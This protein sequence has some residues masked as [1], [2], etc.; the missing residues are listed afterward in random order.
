VAGGIGPDLRAGRVVVLDRYYLSTAAY[1]GALGLDP[2]AIMAENE[3]FAPRPDLAFLLDLPVDT[4]LER[5]SGRGE[6]RS[7]FE[8]RAYLEDV[9]RLFLDLR[10]PYI[11]L[12]EA[13]RPQAD[14]QPA[15]LAIVQRELPEL[16][17]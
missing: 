17:K 4:A 5:I 2:E 3:S 7:A 13:Q 12:I 14:L 16:F 9:R 8:K 10:R 1:Q 11:H 6:T 15:V